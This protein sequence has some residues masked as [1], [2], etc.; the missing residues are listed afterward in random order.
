M[1]VN[2][3]GKREEERDLTYSRRETSLPPSLWARLGE[4]TRHGSGE[5]FEV[6]E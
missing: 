1:R 6:A 2:K 3:G 5:T 4:L